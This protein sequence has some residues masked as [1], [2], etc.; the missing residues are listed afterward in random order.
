MKYRVFVAAGAN[1]GDRAKNIEKAISKLQERVGV[2]VAQSSL[3]E[4]KPFLPEGVFEIQPYY[5]N[6]VVELSSA[7]A[8]QQILT[9]LAAIEAE[10][11]RVRTSRNKWAARSIDLDLLAVGETILN[12]PALV[13]PHP[14]MHLRDFVLQPMMEIA[15]DWVHPVTKKTIKQSFDELPKGR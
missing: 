3:I 12:T 7:L 6:G 9:H 11:G 14:E 5:L 8:P 13:L 1:L 10:L 15:P 2:I 4:T